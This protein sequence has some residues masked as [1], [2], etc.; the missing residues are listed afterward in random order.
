MKKILIALGSMALL[1]GSGC[2][3]GG[4][5]ELLGKMEGFKNKVCACKDKACVDNVQKEMMEWAMK[6][7][8]KYKDTEKKATAAQKEKAEKI[9]DE[10]EKC[11][12]KAS[13]G[14]EA[15]PPAQ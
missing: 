5:D 15:P 8:D 13:G 1:A 3:G 11:V 9:E 2:G 10:M 7:M 4:A 6:N 14:G 12:E